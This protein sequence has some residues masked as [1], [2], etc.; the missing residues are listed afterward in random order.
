[1]IRMMKTTADSSRNFSILSFFL[2]CFLLWFALL[3]VSAARLEK[4]MHTVATEVH[5]I[6]KLMRA[7][8]AAQAEATD[9]TNIKSVWSCLACVDLETRVFQTLP[10]VH[11]A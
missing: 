5:D 11:G 4:M 6:R 10:S 3:N 8:K 9:A 1:M 2:S 7:L